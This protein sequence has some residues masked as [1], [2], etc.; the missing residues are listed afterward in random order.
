MKLKLNYFECYRKNLFHSFAE[1]S[2]VF[3][4]KYSR[5]VAVDDT[6]T[7]ESQDE[8]VVG[9]G[10]LTY[11]MD[12]TVGA[13]GGNTQVEITPNHSFGSQVGARLVFSM[14]RHDLTTQFI[15]KIPSINYFRVISCNIA[16]GEHNIYAMHS[17][18][19]NQLCVDNSR[20]D[21]QSVNG[22]T[23]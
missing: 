14:K 18:K 8:P 20:K 10:D 2:I 16:H 13:L 23:S 7:V 3:Q 5:T 22:L 15:F 11:S 21:N 19:D 6:M 4:C 17:L 12:V 9:T 1:N